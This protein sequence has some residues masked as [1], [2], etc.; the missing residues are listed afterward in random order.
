MSTLGNR[1]KKLR[2]KAG[3]SQKRAAKLIGISAVNLSRYEGDKRTPDKDTLN[4][5]AQFYQVNPS[6]LYFGNESNHLSFLQDISKEEAYLL[7]EYLKE[8]REKDNK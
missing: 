8:I 6:Y 1:L 7:K 3:L 5:I 2:S 4:N